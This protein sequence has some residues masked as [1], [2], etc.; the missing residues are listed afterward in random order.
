M[1]SRILFLDDLRRPDEFI[2]EHLRQ[3]FNWTWVMDYDGFVREISDGKWRDYFLFMMD[4]DLG[5][6]KTGED[7]AKALVAELKKTQSMLPQI[8]V[9]SMNP[10]GKVNMCRVFEDYAKWLSGMNAH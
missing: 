8:I 10:V 3:A 2:P 1:K 9:H 6:G 7:C 5:D 4:H